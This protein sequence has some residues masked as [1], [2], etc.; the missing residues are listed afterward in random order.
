M[1]AKHSKLNEI[2][3]GTVVQAEWTTFLKKI[4]TLGSGNFGTVYLVEDPSNK[5]QYVLK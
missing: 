2:N 1:G 4:K 3:V 5:K